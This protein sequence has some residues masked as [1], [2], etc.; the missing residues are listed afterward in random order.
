MSRQAD[1]FERAA[2]CQRAGECAGDSSQRVA[3]RL[4]RDLWIALANESPSM[5]EAEAAREIA[6]IEMIHERT[7][8]SLPSGPEISGY[9]GRQRNAER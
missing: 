8:A 9:P 4:L 6:A 1:L 5:T 3:L 7:F 2:R